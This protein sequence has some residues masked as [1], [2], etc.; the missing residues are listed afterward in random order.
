MLFSLLALWISDEVYAHSSL[1]RVTFG[2]V[3]A[4]FGGTSGPQLLFF[5]SLLGPCF[6][7]LLYLYYHLIHSLLSTDS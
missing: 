6:L 3:Y 5:G 7:F 4:V 2:F 1:L